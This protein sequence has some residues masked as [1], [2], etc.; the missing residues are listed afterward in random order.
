MPDITNL[1]TKTILNA[2]T[3]EVKA[4]ILSTSGLATASALTAVG[5]KIH[6]ISN[7]V[8]KIGYNTKVNEIGKKVTDNSHDN[9]ITTQEFNKLTT[10]NFVARL[11]Q[12]DFDNILLSLSKKNYFKQNKALNS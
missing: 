4:E 5:N 9:Y 8:K 6:N 10:E 12:T 1:A 7:L 3:N 11:E 2:K